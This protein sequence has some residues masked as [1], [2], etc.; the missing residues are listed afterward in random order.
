ML[1]P[2]SP[3]RWLPKAKSVVSRVRDPVAQADL[4][5]V[6]K[7]AAAAVVAW[8]LA[9]QV[10]DLPQPFLAPWS[11]L[12][13][14]HATV[15]R[16]VSRGVQQV[17]ATVLGVLLSFALAEVLGIN[18]VTLFLAML[19]ALLLARLGLLRDEGVT[20]ATTALFVLTTGYGQQEQL[21]GDRIL[22]TVLGIVV[23]VLVNL[24]VLPPLTHRSAARHVD[25]VDERIGGLLRGMAESVRRNDTDEAVTGWIEQTRDLDRELDHA[26]ESVGYAR[27]STRMNP[28]R[29]AASLA[30][31]E[32]SYEEILYRL[33]DGVAEAR[34]MARTLRESTFA[35]QEW[36]N[37]FR[38]PWLELLEAVGRRIQS[39]D[40]DVG[41]LRDRIDALTRELSVGELAELH[42]PLYGALLTNLRNIVDVVDDVAT[43]QSVRETNKQS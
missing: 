12:L 14:V 7:A 2:M 37:R 18:G 1:L 41:S 16:S 42:W 36:D 33:E 9:V 27:E 5:L 43:T 29:R 15:Y 17:G 28:R 13:T 21:L 24:L 11:A 35:E 30:R 3:L 25:T 19:L 38:E 34:S 6:T 23:G 22:A 26:W 4:L 10:F 31:G 8:L 39:P 20:V 40:A 32:L